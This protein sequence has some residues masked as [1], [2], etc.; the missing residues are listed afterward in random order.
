[1]KNADAFSTGGFQFAALEPLALPDGL[2]QALG[3]KGFVA[4]KVC[5]DGLGTPLR[6]KVFRK[7]SHGKRFWI[8]IG[9]SSIANHSRNREKISADKN[10]DEKRLNATNSNSAC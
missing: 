2:Q 1:M 10:E 6:V 8:L 3:R 7:W 4:Q 5:G 9:A